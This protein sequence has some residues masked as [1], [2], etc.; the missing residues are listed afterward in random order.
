MQSSVLANP[1]TARQAACKL[2]IEMKTASMHARQLTPGGQR[3]HASS[4]SRALHSSRDRRRSLRALKAIVTSS[5]SPFLPSTRLQ[6]VPACMPQ[7]R[8]L[9]DFRALQARNVYA[10]STIAKPSDATKKLLE[11]QQA[12]PLSSA[13][14]SSEQ[15]RVNFSQRLSSATDRRLV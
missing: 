14:A 4:R 7:L 11:A 13:A 10:A 1:Q 5:P 6:P 12:E 2:C 15:L 8:F 3:T 9:I